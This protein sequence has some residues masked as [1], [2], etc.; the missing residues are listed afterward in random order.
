MLAVRNSV[1]QKV[2]V[3]DIIQNEQ[4]IDLWDIEDI[5]QNHPSNDLSTCIKFLKQLQ[6]INKLEK[7][8]KIELEGIE[9][10]LSS[11]TEDYQDINDLKQFLSLEV[12]EKT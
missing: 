9:I 6:E 11:Q 10:S 3:I 7:S 12:W 1:A 5:I 4:E 2:E 8:N